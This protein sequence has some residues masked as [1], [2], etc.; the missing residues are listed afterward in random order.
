MF[1]KYSVICYFWKGVGDT[2]RG[3]GVDHRSHDYCIAYILSVTVRIYVV[4]RMGILIF[5]LDLF[6]NLS[7]FGGVDTN[8]PHLKC[9]AYTV[10]NSIAYIACNRQATRI[11]IV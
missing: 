7:F 9:I 2:L 10:C 1:S 3:G 8:G 6:G 5:F 11:Y 4:Q